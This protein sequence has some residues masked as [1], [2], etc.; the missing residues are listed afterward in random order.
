MKDIPIFTSTE[1]IASLILREIPASR[2]AYVLIRG[3]FTESERLMSE[4]EQFCRLAGAEQVYFSGEAD[5]AGCRVYARLLE[6]SVDCAVL[7]PTRACAVPV[8]AD[9]AAEWSAAYRARFAGVP[10]ARRCVQPQD[11]CLICAAE[12]RIGI[13]QLS[14]DLLLT[15]ASLERGCG[16]D[17]VAA[18]AALCSAPR[19]RLLC[20][21]E[22]APA[23][24]LYDRLGFDCGNVKEIWYSRK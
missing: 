13:G 19:L 14:G 5:F 24:A 15:L 12:R 17:C 16:A 23:M 6:R 20:A 11:A 4:C 8:T 18:M 2:E 1:G 21:M 9:T 7:P 22:N 10:A 3:V